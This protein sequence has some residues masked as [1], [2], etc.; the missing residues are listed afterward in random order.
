MDIQADQRPPLEVPLS[1][2]HSRAQY[3]QFFISDE[4]P[5]EVDAEFSHIEAGSLLSVVLPHLVIQEHRMKSLLEVERY[6][7]QL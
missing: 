3:G 2:M 7:F 6:R 5:E 4:Y 1:K